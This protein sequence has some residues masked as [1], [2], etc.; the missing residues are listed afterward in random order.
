MIIKNLVKFIIAHEGS[1]LI[2][3][4]KI[5]LF[6]RLAHPPKKFISLVYNFLDY[7]KFSLVLIYCPSRGI[8]FNIKIKIKLFMRL[9]PPSKK[10]P[11][12]FPSLV[13]II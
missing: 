4:L 13:Y 11:S 2:L 6:M 7:K 10:F 1:Y 5:N 8:I 3:L 12:K 9:A